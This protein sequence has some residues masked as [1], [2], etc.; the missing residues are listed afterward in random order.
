M[1]YQL[2]NS[3]SNSGDPTVPVIRER[4][5]FLGLPIMYLADILPPELISPDIV[6]EKFGEYKMHAIPYLRTDED[7]GYKVLE[8]SMALLTGPLLQYPLLGGWHDRLLTG[9]QTQMVTTDSIQQSS[10]RIF[11]ATKSAITFLQQYGI[12]MSH[13]IDL[14]WQLY[15]SYYGNREANLKTWK[16]TQRILER[17]PLSS[18]RQ[19]LSEEADVINVVGFYVIMSILDALQYELPPPISIAELFRAYYQ[20]Q[21]TRLNE[22]LERRQVEKVPDLQFDELQ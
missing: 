5:P 19:A 18:I 9:A 12:D 16:V 10:K 3:C 22:Y 17:A 11:Y 13:T 8:S 14:T 6:K 4:M 15:G 20:R 1:D 21:L 2:L 7:D